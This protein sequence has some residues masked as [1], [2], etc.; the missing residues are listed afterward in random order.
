[1]KTLK[2]FGIIL[3]L[4]AVLTVILWANAHGYD[5]ETTAYLQE[6]GRKIA[7]LE[8]LTQWTVDVELTQELNKMYWTVEGIQRTMA[9]CPLRG[10]DNKKGYYC[11]LRWKAK[12]APLYPFIY[13]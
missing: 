6:T 3:A 1:M 4:Y 9:N 11:N 7:V 2:T 5:K 12:I 10:I 8:Q 13:K